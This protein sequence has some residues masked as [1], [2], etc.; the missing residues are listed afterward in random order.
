MTILLT[1]SY[2]E[3]TRDANSLKISTSV[4]LDRS[5]REHIEMICEIASTSATV[6]DV[7]SC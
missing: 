2:F 6:T 4:L 1:I 3:P 7:A 5:R